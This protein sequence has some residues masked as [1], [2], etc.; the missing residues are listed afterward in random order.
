MTWKSRTPCATQSSLTLRVTRHDS[1]RRHVSVAAESFDEI[2]PFNNSQEP[3]AAAVCARP[4]MLTVP[5]YCVVNASQ[6][7][8]LNLHG[9]ETGQSLLSLLSLQWRHFLILCNCR[10]LQLCWKPKCCAHCT[11]ITRAELMMTVMDVD[12]MSIIRSAVMA[13]WQYAG[14][15][16]R[17]R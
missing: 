15:I 2:I 12:V 13:W 11:E 8:T 10:K 7:F 14:C 4:S 17:A 5:R 16:G 9:C 6:N 3:N 1:H